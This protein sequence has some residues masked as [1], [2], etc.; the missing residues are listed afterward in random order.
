MNLCSHRPNDAPG[1]IQITQI[2]DSNVLHHDRLTTSATLRGESLPFCMSSSTKGCSRYDLWQFDAPVLILI[3]RKKGGVMAVPAPA[4][5]WHPVPR[6]GGCSSLR[7]AANV[8]P[9]NQSCLPVRIL[10][11][12]RHASAAKSTPA[13]FRMVKQRLRDII[14]GHNAPHFLA[15]PAGRPFP[16]SHRS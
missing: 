7:L 11:R 1:M 8:L 2:T 14:N 4:G 10:R 16:E 15:R 5:I 6:D 3:A 12:A 9:H 13:I